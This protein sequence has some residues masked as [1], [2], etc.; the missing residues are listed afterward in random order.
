MTVKVQEMMKK[1]KKKK[2]KKKV[3]EVER[4]LIEQRSQRENTFL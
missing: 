2:K 3:A 1:K 4:E